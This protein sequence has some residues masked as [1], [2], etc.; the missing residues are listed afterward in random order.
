MRFSDNGYYVEKYVK[1][2]NCGMLVYGQGSTREVAGRQQLF[3]TPGAS[4]GRRCAPRARGYFRLPIVQPKLPIEI[5]GS[6]TPQTSPPDMVMIKILDC[7]MV[8][9]CRDMG[10]TLMRTSYSTIFNESLDFTCGLA[11]AKGDMIACARFLPD[12]DRRHAA[13]HEDLRAGDPL[14]RR[15]RRVTSSS[16]T[17]PI[18]AACTAPSTPSSSPSSSTA[19]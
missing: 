6:R 12:D 4:N 19:S 16:T 15:W 1:C 5:E 18:A 3:C 10:I 11:D 8:S 13:A 17:I 7:T 2:A 9:I 14:G